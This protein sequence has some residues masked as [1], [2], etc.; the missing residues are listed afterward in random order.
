MNQTLDL[1]TATNNTTKQTTTA[2]SNRSSLTDWAFT[3]AGPHVWNS[4]PQCITD[5]WSPLSFK[6]YL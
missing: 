1:E 3:V 5:C 4:L 6:K 2:T